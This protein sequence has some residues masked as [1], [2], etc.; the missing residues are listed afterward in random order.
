MLALQMIIAA[1]PG[2]I[3]FRDIILEVLKIQKDKK[4]SKTC[5]RKL[6]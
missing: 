2:I 5:L 4:E 6:S 3:S 1:I